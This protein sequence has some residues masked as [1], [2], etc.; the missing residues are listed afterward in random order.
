M[1][2]SP[3]TLFIAIAL[4]C[5]A[6]VAKAL[7]LQHG[8]EMQQPCPLCILQ[9]YAYLAIAL[10]A[11]V[12]ALQV[13][14]TR[15]YAWLIF[16]LSATGVWFTIWQLT[17]GGSMTS[18]LADPVGEFVN[19]LPT[20]GLFEARVFFATGGCADKYAPTFGLSLPVWS[21]ICFSV[22]ALLAVSMALRAKRAPA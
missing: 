13:R 6:L 21:L 4:F 3:R 14:A 2:I 11:G 22:L 15:V 17:K 7:Q 20:A 18:C 9:R 8:P 5:L 1:K 10:V 16:A 19:G 12:G